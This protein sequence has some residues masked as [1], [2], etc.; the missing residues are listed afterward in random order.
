MRRT[1]VKFCGCR[2]ES[3]VEDAIEAG[4]NAVGF[5]LA[6]SPRQITL[7]VLAKLA[8]RVPADIIP[9]AIFVA[10]TRDEMRRIEGLRDD[11]MLQISTHL[12]PRLTTGLRVIQTMQIDQAVKRS[13]IETVLSNL[14]DGTVLFDT[15][16]GK[17]N[18]GT[19]RA[20][21]WEIVAP[22]VSR[23]RSFIAGGLTAKTVG[24][25]I[26]TLRPFG[27]DVSSGIETRGA[28]DSKKM[29]RF[30]AAVEQADES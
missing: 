28:K 14:R 27:V 13:Q 6:P 10:P 7:D 25:C 11:F 19:G 29:R 23:Q 26:R 12:F 4:A 1:K 22:F 8:K 24:T 21:P 15:K 30:I 2:R 18:G 20:F 5:V 17:L 16:L 9:V 3:D